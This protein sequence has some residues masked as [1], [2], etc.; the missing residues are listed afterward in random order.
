MEV[1]LEVMLVFPT[2]HG[3]LGLEITHSNG[4]IISREERP[5][6]GK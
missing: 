3:L 1:T 6:E 2:H 4:L 5:R